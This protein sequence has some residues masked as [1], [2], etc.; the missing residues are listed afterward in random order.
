MK[1][2]GSD[3]FAGTTFGVTASIPLTVFLIN[4]RAERILPVRF[5]SPKSGAYEFDLYFPRTVNNEPIVRPGDKNLELQFPH[6]SI[7]RLRGDRALI[8]FKID[9]MVWEGRADY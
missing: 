6:P 3:P 5:E 7:G 1:S 8:E 9:K 2:K 4:E